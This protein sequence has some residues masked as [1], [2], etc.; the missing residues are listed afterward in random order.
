MNEQYLAHGLS[1]EWPSLEQLGTGEQRCVK[2][3]F[4]IGNFYILILLR[5]KSLHFIIVTTHL[6]SVRLCLYSC[7]KRETNSLNFLF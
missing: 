4:I 3:E 1:A 2:D 6:L 7:Y 5:A